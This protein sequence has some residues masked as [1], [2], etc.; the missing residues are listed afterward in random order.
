MEIQHFSHQH[1]LVF[2]E[3][4]RED[5]EKVYCSGCGEQLVSGPNFSCEDCGFYLDKQCAEAPSQMNHPFHR[6]H[7]LSLLVSSPYRDGQFICDF[8]CKMGERFAYHCSCGLDFHIKCALFLYH[9]LEKKVDDQL[10][11]I[12]Y[13]DP[14]ISNENLFQELKESKCFAC[15]KPLVDSAYLSLD[16]GFS[17]HKKCIELPREINHL[18]HRQHSLFLQFNSGRLPCQICQ[19]TQHGG[20][21]YCCSICNFTLHI[22]C[23]SPSPIIEDKSSHEHPFIRLFRQSS[24]TCDACGTPGNYVSYICSTCSIMVHK[25]CIS[26]P[27]IIKIVWHHHPI[28]HKHFVVDNECGTL[29]CGFCHEEVNKECG[30]YY[31]SECK[32][33]LHVNCALH[34]TEWYYQVESKEDYEKS[35]VADQGD[36]PFFV[37]EDIKSGENVIK[38][39]SHEHNLVLSEVAK[40]DRYCDGCNVVTTNIVV[41]PTN[42]WKICA[43]TF[44]AFDV[45]K[46]LWHAQVEHMSTFFSITT[47][48]H[49][50]DEHLLTLKYHEGNYYSKYLHC[51]ICEEERNPNHWFYHC[52]ICD[53]SAHVNCVLGDFPF[54][55]LGIS[56]KGIKKHPHPL[57]L[58]KKVYDY[59]ERCKSC[60]KPC[61]DLALECTKE[62][63]NYI[64]HLESCV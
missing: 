2:N 41:S 3:E 5:S 22:D 28:F 50:C 38:H 51:D 26:L 16:Y 25:K 24:F 14:S 45:L 39:F 61:L 49:K 10:Q 40:D 64:T 60:G 1:P 31:C 27:R 7:S 58:V 9:I 20:L 13:K 33:I 62:K 34:N 35:L 54:V 37:I 59:P 53:T 44:P 36:P 32:F 46:Y 52:A 63:C 8:C 48:R 21:V 23:V 43:P 6:S 19:E 15:W 56:I 11:H 4:R 30:S 47:A 18:C 29:E 42:V 55:K 12:T 17:L 57:V